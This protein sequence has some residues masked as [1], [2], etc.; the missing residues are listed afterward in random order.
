MAGVQDSEGSYIVGG[1]LGGNQVVS[2]AGTIIHYRHKRKK[3]SN[4]SIRIAE[5]TQ[6]ILRVVVS[7][8]HVFIL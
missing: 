2:A 5:P 8:K 7:K 3:P 1:H 6:E 4:D